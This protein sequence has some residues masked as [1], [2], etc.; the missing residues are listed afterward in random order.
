MHVRS[1]KVPRVPLFQPSGRQ[2][3]LA[4]SENAHR[5]LGILIGQG[6]LRPD[7]GPCFLDL[8]QVDVIT[9]SFL[10]DCLLGYRNHARTTVP[11]LYPVIANPAPKVLYERSEE[12]TSELQSPMYLVCRLLLEKKNKKTI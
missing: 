1:V 2:E 9:S 10:R 5:V 8:D 11:H 6:V 3:V 7:P 4:G 12:H